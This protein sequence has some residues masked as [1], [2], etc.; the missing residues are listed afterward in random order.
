M[1]VKDFILIDTKKMGRP[2]EFVEDNALIAAMNVF[3]EKGYDGAS[4]KHL[5]KAMGISGPSIY[6]TFG[7]KRELFLKA[8]D[9]YADIDACAPVIA[10]KTEPDIEKAVKEFFKAI[11]MYAVEN[12]SGS[13]GCFLVTSVIANINEV[14]GVAE[15]L[16]KAIE[17]S[18]THLATRFE[19]EKEK[20]NLP[21][22]FPSKARARLMFDMRQSYMFRARA[23]WSAE[24]LLE[25][26]DYRVKMIVTP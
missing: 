24:V 21:K 20:G 9:R 5:I 15:R 16:E 13:G 17:Y 19:L 26:I 23:G 2:R 6:A 12:D 1:H 10:L 14:D 4:L 18:D 25:D 11:V 7:D 8:I 3:W 22:D